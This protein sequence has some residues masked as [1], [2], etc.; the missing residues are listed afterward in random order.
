MTVRELCENARAARGFLSAATRAQKDAALEAAAAALWARREEIIGANG[1]DMK[2]ARAAGLPEAMCDR[3]LLTKARVADIC[4][5]VRAVAALPDP[6]GVT[7]SQNTRSNGLF[8]E[9]VTVPM[10]VIAVIFEARPNVSA[11]SAALCLK[12]GNAAVLRGGKEA[13]CSNKAIVAAF[14]AALVSAGFP[15]DC[16]CLVEDTSHES[17]AQLMRQVGLVD[18]LIPRG[19]RSLIQAV[20]SEAAVP[21]IETGA[22]VCHIYVDKSADVDMAADIIYNAK[23]SRPSV[24]N[25]CECI[26]V[27]RDIADSALPAIWARLKTAGVELR[28]DEATREIVPGAAPA[29][30]EDYGM[31]YNALILACRVVDGEDDALA[32]ID[33]YGTKHSEAIITRDDAAARRFLARV[34][35]AA[36][37]VNASTRFTDGGVFGLGAEIGISTQKLHARGPLGLREL[38]TYKYLIRGDG[39]TR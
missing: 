26:L 34:D 8:I 10:G 23:V 11:D 27:H 25:A 22:G 36:V 6:V 5:G 20:V 12:S 9:K 2:N 21:V 18:L 16:V 4:A 28:G 30:A 7:L 14:R 24:C 37:Y 15:A 32:H 33:R 29:K 3:L 35:A 31:E 1:E 39:Q 38:T 19:G 13:I 17:A